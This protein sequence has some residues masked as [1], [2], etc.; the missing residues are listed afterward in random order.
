M[1]SE[2]IRRDRER[3]NRKYE[4]DDSGRRRPDPFLTAAWEDFISPLFPRG[5]AALD[6]AGGT[7]RHAVWLARAGWQVT[8]ADISE[9][10]IARARRRARALRP[11]IRFQAQPAH[12][13]VKGSGR[14]D[15]IMV[16]YYLER[17]LFPA[18]ARALRPEGLLIYKTF[19]TFQ[20]SFC[21]GPR[22]AAHLLQSNELLRAF[23]K[24]QVLHYQ[25]TL[26]ERAVAE[27]VGRK[28]GRK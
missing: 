16:F 17:G 23:S 27:F 7:G 13:A 3:W 22:D 6:L 8:L 4:Q 21:E 20:K 25:E 26:R 12:E 10:A 1:E 14:F 9:V 19:T 11:L 18:L 15:L 28:P 5:G 24:F 2:R